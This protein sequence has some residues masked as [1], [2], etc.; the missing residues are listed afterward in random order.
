MIPDWVAT[1]PLRT[2]TPESLL[3]FACLHSIRDPEAALLCAFYAYLR[4]PV[5]SAAWRAARALEAV[6]RPA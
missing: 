6:L 1:S 2:A 3:D 5:H 4:S